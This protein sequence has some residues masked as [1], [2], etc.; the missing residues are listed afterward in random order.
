MSKILVVDDKQMMR[1][2]VS[3]TLV[4]AGFQA[5]AAADG[6]TAL[7]MIARH[8][9][10]AVVS[11]L[12]MPEVDGI[13]LLRRIAEADPSLPVILMTAFAT[14]D[15]AVEAMKLGAFDY[16]QKPFEGDEL[17]VAVKRAVEHRRLRQEN[18]ALR[19]AGD[20]Q[21]A[22]HQLIGESA[23]MRQ[24]RRQ[25]DQVAA[26]HGTV[27]IC[28]ESGTGK[29][30]VARRLHAASPRRR[31]VMLAVNC[32][33]LS[34]SLLESELFGHE[35]GAFTGA[36]Q[37]RKGRFELADGGTLMLD[38]VSEIEPN[39]QAKLL[40]VLQERQFERVGSSVTIDVDVRVIAT[41]NRDLGAAVAA[42]QF[43]ED[44]Y[45]RLNVLPL[46]VPPLRE[47]AE[48]VPALAE[49]FLDQQG[50]RDG[51]AP[52][53]FEAE[54]LEML[55]RYHWPGNVRELQ[56]ICERAGVLA[57]G[58]QIPADLIAPWLGARAETSP[59]DSHRRTTDGPAPA[60]AIETAV[61]DR[62]TLE[63]F[64]R[65]LIIR[66]LKK[67]NGHRQQTAE[68]LGI[69]VRT[70]GLKLRKWKES[71]LVAQSL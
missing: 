31:S 59:P 11:D 23:V 19:S 44:L 43:R 15:T 63:E 30:V 33:A 2:S 69:G 55:R 18:E 12:K 10:A 67:H 14:I 70:L 7:Q 56:N 36:D 5:V 4:R 27:L 29:E 61:A 13:E 49:H 47:R 17:V 54:A 32:A 68:A 58:E 50:R 64:E 41:T 65:E 40:R 34:A 38:E 1:D 37:L 6:S 20:E 24:L 26:S 57:G 35:K 21:N 39:L 53:R 16:V 60:P 62:Q 28:G 46:R 25:I 52:K 3:T 22:R 45:F 48:D 9:P 8:R 51:R 66:T 71:N 42:G